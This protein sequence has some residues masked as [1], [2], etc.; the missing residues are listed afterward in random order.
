MAYNM[1]NYGVYPKQD[2]IFIFLLRRNEEKRKKKEKIKK[3]GDLGW[4]TDFDPA[5]N[6]TFDSHKIN[7]SVRFQLGVFKFNMGVFKFNLNDFEY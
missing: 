3:K 4:N 2:N 7:S 1:E 6:S 5:P